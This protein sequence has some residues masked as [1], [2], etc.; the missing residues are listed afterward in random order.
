MAH[1][2][3]PLGGTLLEQLSR[4]DQIRATA[5]SAARVDDNVF[6]GGFLAAADPHFIRGAGITR[7][8]KF[9][10]DSPADPPRVPGVSYLVVPARD[11]PDYDIRAGAAAALAFI[12]D[13]IRA[14]ERILVHC[15]AGVSRSATVVLLHLMINRGYVLPLALAHLR[16]VRAVAQPNSGFMKHLRATDAR[17]RVLRVGD[18]KEYVAPPPISA[19]D[20][21]FFWRE[22][23]PEARARWAHAGT[24]EKARDAPPA[25]GPGGPACCR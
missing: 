20:A 3:P 4:A 7:I 13:G 12:R 21:A 17:L 19:G 14:N 18:E 2:V 8:V 9:C 22:A 15:V 11:S 23:G 16:S 5:G 24:G 1:V 10:P 25:C 6:I